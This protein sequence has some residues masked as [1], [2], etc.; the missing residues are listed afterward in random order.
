MSCHQPK[1]CSAT[2]NNNVRK[3]AT[4]RTNEG[5]ITDIGRGGVEGLRWDHFKSRDACLTKTNKP[6]TALFTLKVN[7]LKATPG[8]FQDTQKTP[9]PP[10]IPTIQQLQLLN[11]KTYPSQTITSKHPKDIA[12]HSW[13]KFQ[14]HANRTDVVDKTGARDF[15]KELQRTT[16]SQANILVPCERMP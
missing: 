7:P 13:R 10:K 9:V 12:S 1:L 15:G 5:N 3:Y 11:Y 8:Q 2:Y 4:I 14:V 6:F 16:H